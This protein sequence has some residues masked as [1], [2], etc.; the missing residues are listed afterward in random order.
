MIANQKLTGQAVKRWQIVQRV[1]AH[2]ELALLGRTIRERPREIQD[3]A[4]V[5]TLHLD[6]DV[7]YFV[8]WVEDHLPF[9]SSKLLKFI[10][11][12]VH[13]ATAPIMIDPFE[14]RIDLLEAAEHLVE[15]V[16]LEHQEDDVLDGIVLSLLGVH[17]FRSMSL[18]KKSV[19]ATSPRAS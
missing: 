10:T 6:L 7:V 17:C 3:E 18:K 5:A 8:V 13:V 1:V 2:N 12:G 4:A 9:P 15:G 11:G 16:I 19:K 14:I